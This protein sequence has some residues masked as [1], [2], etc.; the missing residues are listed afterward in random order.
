[1][2]ELDISDFCMKFNEEKTLYQPGAYNTI[3]V[4]DAN[5]KLD[6][7]LTSAQYHGCPLIIGELSRDDIFL[8]LKRHFLNK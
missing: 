2:T 5:G 7:K 3:V 1:M 4:V 8:M 6:H